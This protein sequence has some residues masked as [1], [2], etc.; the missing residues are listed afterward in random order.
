MGIEVRVRTSEQE[1]SCHSTR[2]LGDQGAAAVS[3]GVH[4][5][6]EGHGRQAHGRGEGWAGFGEHL[7]GQQRE[8][9]SKGEFPGDRES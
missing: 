4:I 8:L 9:R 5:A 6:Q 7:G 1:V 2:G 3:P